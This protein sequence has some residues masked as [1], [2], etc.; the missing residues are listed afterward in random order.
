MEPEVE[1]LEVA[2]EVMAGQEVALDQ[3]YSGSELSSQLLGAEENPYEGL[4]QGD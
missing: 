3:P 2:V 1:D 4:Q